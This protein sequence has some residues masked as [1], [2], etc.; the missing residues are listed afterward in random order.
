MITSVKQVVDAELE[1][2]MRNYAYYKNVSTLIGGGGYFDMSMSSGNP[3][4]K[5]WFDAPP[6]VA[7]QVSQSE[8][9]GLYH[10]ANVAPYTK[11]IRQ[12]SAQAIGASTVPC[13]TI[14]CDY[15]LYYPS[16]DESNVGDTSL[17]NSV[18]LPRY[19]D[20]D[21][22][23]ILPIVTAAGVGGAQLYFT[24]TNSDG[25]SGRISRTITTGA[26]NSGVVLGA[27]LVNNV[28]QPFV[29]LQDGDTGVR[30]VETVTMLSGDGGLF[31]LLLVKPLLNS[32]IKEL[33]APHEKDLL[34]QDSSLPIVQ[35]DAFLGL[36][37]MF[38]TGFPTGFRGELKVIWN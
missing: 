15:L 8:D 7:K 27:G 19:T 13:T 1:G 30:S 23:M 2:R 22:V 26:L 12:F 21:G 10:G 18:T 20:G 5:Y 31:S 28:T 3:R 11:Y 14:L 37:S 35:D 16:I 33:A 17:T 9:G 6:N 38:G 32:G 25:V 34:I 24:Y 4:A 36:V 29:G